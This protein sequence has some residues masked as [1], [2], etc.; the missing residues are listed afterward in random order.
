MRGQL[1]WDATDALHLRFIADYNN[2]ESDCCAGVIKSLGANDGAQYLARIAATG[3]TYEFD[4]E[5]PHGLDQRLAAHER[6]AGRHLGRGQL[7]VRRVHADIHHRV[8]LLGLQALQRCRRRFAEC[9]RQR[10]AAG[11]RRTVEPGTALGLAERAAP[12]NTSRVCTTST[13]RR[14]TSCSRSTART[15]ASGSAAR[16]SSTATRRPTRTCTRAAIRCSR[17]PPGTS[18]TSSASPAACAARASRRTR[19]SIDCRPRARTPVSPRCCRRTTPAIS[20]APTP[21]YSG[22]LSASYK[23]SDDALLYASVSR[24]AK[25]GGIN[26]SVPPT[27]AGGLPANET[28]FIEPEIA[29]DYELGVKTNL[30]GH[31]VQLN[32]QSVLDRRGRLPGHAARHSSPVPACPRRYSA[33]SARCARAASRSNSRQCPIDGLT[34]VADGVVQRCDVHRLQERTLRRRK[35]GRAVLRSHGRTAVPHARVGRESRA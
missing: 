7:E 8:S 26:P 11:Q 21:T 32:A 19:S 18:P 3:A 12:S 34:L 24:G 23:L 9:H 4:P 6:R 15:P 17:R 20:N 2:E 22:L 27:V 10:R 30:L 1:L 35:A 28:L 16:S 29:L 5:L 33:T 14:T 13:S 31:R 25:S